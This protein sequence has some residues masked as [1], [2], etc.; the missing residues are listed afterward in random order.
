MIPGSMIC[1]R[2]NRR[3]FLFLCFT[4]GI[5]ATALIFFVGKNLVFALYPT[6]WHLDGVAKII[7]NEKP[8]I[9]TPVK[10]FYLVG[11]CVKATGIGMNCAVDSAIHLANMI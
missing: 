11:D 3:K 7:N 2:I 8:E 5:L 4:F 9:V 10:N 1:E 6:T